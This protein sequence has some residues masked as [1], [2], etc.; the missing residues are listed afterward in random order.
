M[1]K[2]FILFALVLGLSVPASAQEIF[3]ALLKE[4]KAVVNNPKSNV[5]LAKIAQFKCTGLQYIHDKAIESEQQV[6]TKFL[7]DQAYYMN[8]FIN[9]FIKDALINTSLSKGD[10][11]KRILLFIDASGSNPLFND[12][13][14]EV[15]HAYV[16]TENQLTPFSLDTDWVKA[17]AA[18]QSKMQD[19][20]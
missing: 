19:G 5:T 3:N 7:D 8:Q 17:Y 15:V 9:S 4:A 2:L 11:K 18:V 6:T 14:K 10:K 16:T 1:K 13:D 20:K 12:P